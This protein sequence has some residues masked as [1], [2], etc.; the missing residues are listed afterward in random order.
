MFF[1]NFD[2]V[3]QGQKTLDS[4][5]EIIKYEHNRPFERKIAVMNMKVWCFV[6]LLRFIF[7][8]RLNL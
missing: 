6:P 3:S 8:I 2:L 4:K 1:R 5:N 7:G